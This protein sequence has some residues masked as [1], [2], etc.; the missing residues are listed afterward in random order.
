MKV[1]LSVHHALDANT[2]A[3]GATLALAGALRRIGHETRVIGF[4]ALPD[5]LG[6]VGKEAVFPL[7]GGREIARQVRAWRPDV[8]DAST[9]DAWLWAALRGRGGPA[10]VTRSHGLE[11]RLWAARERDSARRCEPLALRTR[12]YHGRYRL[13]EVARSVRA[14][15]LVLV[16]N[17][18]DRDFAVERLR[19]QPT[20]VRVTANGVDAGLLDAPPAG[21]GPVTGVLAIGSWTHVKGRDFLAAALGALLAA[22]PAL[23]VKLLGTLTPSEEVRA[24]FPE[25]V[26]TR[27]RV[28]ERYERADLP[29]LAAGT[30]VYVSASVSEGF[31]LAML[32]GMALG[33]APVVTALPAAREVLRDGESGLL[34]A[35][36]D[37]PALT[38]A[39]ERVV[40]DP[41]LRLRL[42]LA[43]RERAA[44]YTWEAVA[45]RTAAF[46]EQ[47]VALRRA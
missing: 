21:D 26:R 32:E 23:E 19:V 16:L 27:V 39:L 25:L 18:E 17:A 31:P 15:D 37:A 24:A 22:H 9:G 11:H 10:L 28:V 47:A 42:A 12:L 46:Y 7:L 5:R 6:P 3:P 2:G 36:A 1:L 41:D 35:P 8:V 33:L 4:D 14:A 43:A 40:A 45:R 20:R 13:W 34:V 38:A 30:Q 44:D 29:R